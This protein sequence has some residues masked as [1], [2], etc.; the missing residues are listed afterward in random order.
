MARTA[1]LSDPATC[2]FLQA[3]QAQIWEALQ[4]QLFWLR[5][6]REQEA[7]CFAAACSSRPTRTRSPSW[8]TST[9]ASFSYGELPDY[10]GA[11]GL[12]LSYAARFAETGQLAEVQEICE[13]A[14]GLPGS[15]T[16]HLRLIANLA[17][18][19]SRAQTATPDQRA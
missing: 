4:E 14:I 6:A 10:A 16:D 3:L 7:G 19:I 8:K 5:E 12:A 9:G 13:W 17:R 15:D 2:T 1:A 18:I 11:L